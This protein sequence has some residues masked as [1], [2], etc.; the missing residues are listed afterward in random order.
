MADAG[1]RLAKR[2][3]FFQVTGPCA[4]SAAMRAPR[5]ERQD[6]KGLGSKCHRK[7]H[8]KNEKKT[9]CRETSPTITRTSYHS[10]TNFLSKTM[11][12]IQNESDPYA[13]DYGT[14]TPR[15]PIKLNVGRTK[16]TQG[17]RRS[18][19][20][21]LREKGIKSRTLDA[22][23]PPSSTQ[24]TL[25]QLRSLPPQATAS[26]FSKEADELSSSV[27]SSGE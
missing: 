12:K 1:V 3:L 22:M 13:T 17:K 19:E 15:H 20:H 14:R 8:P 16:P 23:Q 18:D 10:A 6:K 27:P 26:I 5:G 25:S 21:E 4:S 7:I 24:S 9:F 2:M 11:L